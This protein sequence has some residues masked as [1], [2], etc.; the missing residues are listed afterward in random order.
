MFEKPNRSYIY[1][2]N[3]QVWLERQLDKL[4]MLTVARAR[5]I[6][7]TSGG[8]DGQSDPSSP[9]LATRHVT[10]HALHLNVEHLH[11]R[12][13]NRDRGRHRERCRPQRGEEVGVLE[14]C[15]CAGALPGRRSEGELVRCPP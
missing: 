6:G 5:N 10:V 3:I 7:L 9:Q 14:V 2:Y 1:I 4:H 13:H 15:Q 11:H 8:D 12:G